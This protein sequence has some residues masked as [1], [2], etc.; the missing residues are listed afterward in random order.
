MLQVWGSLFN[1]RWTYLDKYVMPLSKEIFDA[2][3]QAKVFNILN[4]WFSYHKLRVKEGDKVKM[5]FW[6]IDPNGKDYLYQWQFLPFSLKNAHKIFQ[7]IMNQML[8]NI[9]FTKC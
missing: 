2:L 1:E 4:L 6:G 3:W 9:G 7:R 5:V 8:A